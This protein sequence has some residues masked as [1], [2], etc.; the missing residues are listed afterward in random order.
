MQRKFTTDAHIILFTVPYKIMEMRT[1]PLAVAVLAFNSIFFV[2][3][4]VPLMVYMSYSIAQEKETGIRHLLHSNGLGQAIH[5]LSWLAH[6]MMINFLISLL[7]SLTM[8]MVVFKN[9]SIIL[10]FLVTFIGI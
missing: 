10:Y 6:Y 7:Y 4:I 2:L 5:Y 1:S 3:T 8:K 9:D